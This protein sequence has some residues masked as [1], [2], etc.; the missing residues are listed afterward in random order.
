[1]TSPTIIQQPGALDVATEAFQRSFA[2]YRQLAYQREQLSLAKA[3]AASE[4]ALQ[5][6]EAG[7]AKAR[8]KGL[9]EQLRLADAQ[10]LGRRFAMQNSQMDDN[11]FM[12]A[13]QKLLDPDALFYANE[14]RMGT[15]KDMADIQYQRAHAQLE[16]LQ[17]ADLQKRAARDEAVQHVLAGYS[18]TDIV[19]NPATQARALAD[20][21][22][23]D[24]EAAFKQAQVFNQM[25]HNY[26]IE[27]LPDGS[28]LTADP[29]TGHWSIAAHAWGGR[30][31]G[32]SANAQMNLGQRLVAAKQARQALLN[33]Q[34]I[35]RVD[36]EGVTDP[37]TVTTADD[38]RGILGRVLGG[39]AGQTTAQQLRSANQQRASMH[40]NVFI[41]NYFKAVPGG[42]TPRSQV[43]I[44]NFRRG[45]LPIGP[46]KPGV[47]E[48]AFQNRVNLLNDLNDYIG[49]LQGA[50]SGTNT[51]DPTHM[52]GFSEALNA[53]GAVQAASG[54][55]GGTNYG[56]RPW[57]PK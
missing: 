55:M 26:H 53:D 22:A 30:P 6:A 3:K 1:M 14:A 17:G 56:D 10:L 13:G 38:A 54:T 25:S 40:G 28:V 21:M 23:V 39:G 48:T 32:G 9:E 15:A 35:Y 2:Q 4:I 52:P 33:L 36:K 49:Q 43:F 50:L 24:E 12:A 37:P 47:A 29:K 44:T 16:Q 19:T 27:A 45:Y 34:A 46:L 8:T 51:V 7:E 41:D 20:V 5:G 31:A 11:S 42:N 57:A 18:H